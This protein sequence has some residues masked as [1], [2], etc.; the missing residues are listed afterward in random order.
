[1][2]QNSDCMQET[3]FKIRHFERLSKSLKKV[4]LF[5]LS[6]P[7]RFNGQSYQKRGPEPMPS[8]SSSYETSTEKFLYLLY[9]I[10]PSL[11][12]WCKVVVVL[13]QKLHQ[14]FY[15]SHFMTLHSHL[16]FWISKVWK[17][18]NYKNLKILRTKRH[19]S[20]K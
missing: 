12:I 14:Q 11:M 18:K 3:L 15:A 1:M 9:I 7:V 19:F 13:F 10:G 8:C 20:M 16:S 17:G 5:F 4:T 6:N 2:T